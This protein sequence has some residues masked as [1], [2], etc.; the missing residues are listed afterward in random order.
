[1]IL[2]TRNFQFQPM[3]DIVNNDNAPLADDVSEAINEY[4]LTHKQRAMIGNELAN[5]FHVSGLDK[6]H[7]E[8]LGEYLNRHVLRQLGDQA[9]L[10]DGTFGDEHK[11]YW[12][13]LGDLLI[14]VTIKQF[15]DKE[16]DFPEALRFLFDSHGFISDNP[17]N[18]IYQ[19]YRSE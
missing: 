3:L 19:M 10:V 6:H 16:V 17:N 18:L 13:M 9:E 1:M 11:H 2:V 15:Q 12:L 5:V 14:D 7:H 4:I 8:R